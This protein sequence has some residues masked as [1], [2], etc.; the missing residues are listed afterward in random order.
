VEL[1]EY[2]YFLLRA[3]ADLIAILWHSTDMLPFTVTVKYI[4]SYLV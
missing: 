1:A 3:V 4:K 2:F